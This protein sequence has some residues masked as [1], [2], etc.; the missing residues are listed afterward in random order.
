[1]SYAQALM[2]DDD[3][4]FRA[5]AEDMVLD[6]GVQS[7]EMADNGLDALAK[8]DAGYAPDLLICDLNMPAHDGVSLV[9]SLADRRFPGKVLII[10]GEDASVIETVA[11]LARMQGLDIIGS[12]RKPLTPEA[13]EAAFSRGAPAPRKADLAPAL[14]SL[15]DAAINRGGLHPFFQAKV[16]MQTGIITGAEA[17]ARIAVTPTEFANPVPYVELAERNNRIDDLTIAL[18]HIVAK[19]A[20]TFFSAG[21]P[22]PV[23]INISP[24]S[25]QRRDFPDILADAVQAAGLPCSQVMLEVTETRLVEYGPDALE[26]MS[27]MRIKGFGL[28]VDDFGTGYSNI[29]RLQMYPF[30]ELKID[31]SFTRGVLTDA[32]ARA[33]VETS[34]RLA[35]E[36]GLKIVAEGVETIEMW[37]YLRDLGIDEAQGYLMAKPMPPSEFIK[38]L[39]RGVSVPPAVALRA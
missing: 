4:V 21:K 37:N 3:P 19:H 14:P 10:S 1:M 33:C 29:D 17:L 11:K 36:L 31:Q 26:V 5:L 35:K 25:L 20:K 13:L 28:S 15:L 6:A 38:L 12:I 2:V 24:I 8:L 30:T 34:V 22:L 18:M 23:S 32:F 9:R 39:E 7:V 27:R 16:S